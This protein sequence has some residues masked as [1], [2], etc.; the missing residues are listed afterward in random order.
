MVERVFMEIAVPFESPN[1]GDVRR[2]V[3]WPLASLRSVSY[4][5]MIAHEIWS[6]ERQNGRSLSRCSWYNRNAY[7]SLVDARLPVVPRDVSKL[8]LNIG[9]VGRDR[10]R[11]RNEV[12]ERGLAVFDGDGGDVRARWLV[13][14][15]L[16]ELG[17]GATGGASRSRDVVSDEEVVEVHGVRG[18]EALLRGFSQLGDAARSIPTGPL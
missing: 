18:R 8:V 6:G 4:D 14:A 17:R 5:R 1:A 9:R 10:D 12:G 16:R 2:E 7:T 13:L 11:L 15:S 3:G